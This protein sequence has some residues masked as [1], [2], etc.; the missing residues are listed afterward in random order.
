MNLPV[1]CVLGPPAEQSFH[2]ANKKLDQCEL[3]N[4]SVSG[5]SKMWLLIVGFCHG[6]APASLQ[7]G[8]MPTASCWHMAD[9]IAQL[10]AEVKE[11]KTVGPVLIHVI[12]DKGR[13]Y[14][15]SLKASD[16]MH[17]VTKFDPRTGTQVKGKSTVSAAASGSK[18]SAVMAAYVLICEK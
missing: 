5:F 11:T 14:D 15:P 2:A 12:T 1:C 17:G 3:F 13:G 8:R 16:R 7:S 4:G 10:P 6:D 18:R 9:L